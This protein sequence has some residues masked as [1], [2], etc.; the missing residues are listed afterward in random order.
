MITAQDVFIHKTNIQFL[1]TI[2]LIDDKIPVTHSKHSR[3]EKEVVKEAELG[4]F[5]F[6]ELNPFSQQKVIR[7]INT[8]RDLTGYAIPGVHNSVKPNDE[9]PYVGA[10]IKK[11]ESNNVVL[12][13]ILD[14]S[15]LFDD[16]H[17]SI[18]LSGSKRFDFNGSPQFFN[19]QVTRLNNNGAFSNAY[20]PFENSISG[21]IYDAKHNIALV[22][23]DFPN[24]ERFKMKDLA[25]SFISYHPY[26]LGEENVVVI[27]INNPYSLQ[28]KLNVP[29]NKVSWNEDMVNGVVDSSQDDRVKRIVKNWVSDEFKKI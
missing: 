6:R 24:E 27:G 19:Y 16:I 8:I 7:Q 28:E 9:L 29:Y 25:K 14:G 1:N 17:P 11:S 4:L 12:G 22:V 3:F 21:I 20:E 10:I 18:I 26:V 13:Q 15:V 23:G 5:Y 2:K